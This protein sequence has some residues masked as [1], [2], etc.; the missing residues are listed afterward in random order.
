MHDSSILGI[1]YNLYKLC[2]FQNICII[3]ICNSV[4]V[5]FENLFIKS[6]NNKK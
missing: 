5:I 6:I 3:H 4:T 1:I 2:I